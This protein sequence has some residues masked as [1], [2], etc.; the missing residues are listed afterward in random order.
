MAIGV[1]DRS[2]ISRQS[3]MTS[4]SPKFP[5]SLRCL[6]LSLSLVSLSEN[7]FPRALFAPSV[8]LAKRRDI[9]ISCQK[10]KYM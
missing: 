9:I 10:K 4:C 5:F 2:I 3:L 8:L 1:A 6:S 7:G